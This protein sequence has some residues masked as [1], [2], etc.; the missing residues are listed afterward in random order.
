[1]TSI[2]RLAG[3]SRSGGTASRFVDSTVTL[4]CGA[5]VAHWEF[6]DPTGTTVVALHGTPICGLCFAPLHQAAKDR[7]IRLIAPDRPG[8]GH[9]SP[10]PGYAVADWTVVLRQFADVL[11][12]DRYGLVGW[13][14]GGPY[15]LAVAAAMPEQLM[16]VAVV[17]A[18]APVRDEADLDLYADVDRDILRA[19]RLDPER[20]RAQVHSMVRQAEQD[21]GPTFEALVAGLRESDRELMTTL[22]PRD[23]AFSFFPAIVNGAD[24]L[25]DDYLALAKDWGFELGDIRIPVRIF[26]GDSDPT[27]P[28]AVG[29]QLC[30]Q[31]AEGSLVVLPDEGHLLIYTHPDEVLAAAIGAIGTDVSDRHAP[32]LDQEAQLP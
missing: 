29:Q 27:I 15:A 12:L 17:A 13:S 21:P 18:M 1:M 19:A 9:S 32:P 20:L 30:G 24:G 6:G 5:Y 26:V 11:G 10:I 23:E 28:V 14:S 22:G 31:L 8:V 4:P 25:T 7:G 2:V 16:G 3:A